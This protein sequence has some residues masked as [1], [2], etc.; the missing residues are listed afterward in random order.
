MVREVT[1]IVCPVG[2]RMTITEENG[3]YTFEGNACKRGEKYGMEEITNPKRVVTTTVKLEGS[4]LPL[5]PVK[6]QEPIPKGMIMDIMK[7]LDQVTIK[8]PV[9]VGDIIVENILDTGVDIV[10]TKDM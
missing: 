8:A 7:E 6:T 10:S 1:C 5:L 3:E 9:S 2:C 4:Y